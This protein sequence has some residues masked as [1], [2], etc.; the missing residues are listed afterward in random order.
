MFGF[1]H[2][3]KVNGLGFAALPE[4]EKWLIMVQVIFNISTIFL[5]YAPTNGIAWV[6]VTN[7]SAWIAPHR[8]VLKPCAVAILSKSFL[9][10]I[11]RYLPRFETVHPVQARLSPALRNVHSLP[12]LGYLASKFLVEFVVLSR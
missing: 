3:R 9:E 4:D 1:E 11:S 12:V 6:L 2:P 8:H 10:Q 5:P 7:P